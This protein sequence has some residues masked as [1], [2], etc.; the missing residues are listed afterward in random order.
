M[1]YENRLFK[2]NLWFAIGCD[3]RYYTSFFANAYNPLVGQFYLQDNKKMAYAP[4]WDVFLNV[5]IRTV[6]VSLLGS[7]LTQLIQ[8]RPHYNGYLYPS[9]DA[10]FRFFVTWRFLE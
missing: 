3:L 9:K 7:D 1:Y 5:K 4:V 2:K 8:G 10:S 6:R